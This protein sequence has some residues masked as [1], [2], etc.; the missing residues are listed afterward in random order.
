MNDQHIQK[1]NNKSRQQQIY[2][3]KTNIIKQE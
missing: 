3:I 1:Q 2:T